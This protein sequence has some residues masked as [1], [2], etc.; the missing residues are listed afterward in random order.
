[1]GINVILYHG[2]IHPHIIGVDGTHNPKKYLLFSAVIPG[3]IFTA[4]WLLV[5][6]IHLKRCD[7][8]NDQKNQTG[9]QN[10]DVQHPLNKQAGMQGSQ[11]QEEKDTDLSMARPGMTGSSKQQKQDTGNSMQGNQSSQQKGNIG[12]DNEGR[13]GKAH[14]QWPADD[15][16]VNDSAGQKDI[17]QDQRSGNDKKVTEPE[18]DTPVQDPEKTEKKIP[19][20][21]SNKNSK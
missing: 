18:I 19:Q 8:K 13:I 10:Q 12:I 6:I 14:D 9:Q 1:L 20:M 2:D 5:C 17:Q 16:K 15:N 21:E 11:E 7:M 4:K 3:I